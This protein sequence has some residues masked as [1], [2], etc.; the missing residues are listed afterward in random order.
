VAAGTQIM[1]VQALRIEQIEEAVRRRIG[2]AAGVSAVAVGGD[3]DQVR[4]DIEAARPGVVHR[5]GGAEADRLR[6]ELE[7]LTGKPVVLNMLV[8]PGP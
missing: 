5:H 7:E 6:A 4:V 2:Q 8:K 3:L 1:T